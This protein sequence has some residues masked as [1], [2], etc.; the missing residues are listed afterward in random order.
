VVLERSRQLGFLG[1][2]PVDA[3]LD[4]SAVFVAA[5]EAARP[6]T[7]PAS[8]LDLGSGGGVPG[9]ILA[10][11][12]LDAEVLLLDSMVRR[13]S[14]LEEAVDDLSLSDRVSVVTARAEDAGRTSQRGRFDLV[15]ARSFAAAPVTAECAAPLVKV[16][17]LVAVAE[18][19]ESGPDRWPDKPLASLGLRRGPRIDEPFHVQV[20][21]QVGPVPDRYPRKVGVPGKRPLWDEHRHQPRSE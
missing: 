15:V 13:T 20:L 21:E 1:P 18:P 5:W 2:G 11:F 14:F 8:V 3:H 16:G 12:W 17:G 6:G 7:V 4:H 10:F 9:L 19:P